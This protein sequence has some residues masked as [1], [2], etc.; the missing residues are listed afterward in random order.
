MPKRFKIIEEI[1]GTIE[2]VAGCAA[3]PGLTSKARVRPAFDDFQQRSPGAT[4]VSPGLRCCR[5]RLA[6][7]GGR[8]RGPWWCFCPLTGTLLDARRTTTP[9]PRLL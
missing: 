2:R 1:T 8:L 7:K 5:W 9:D 6:T 4:R 3:A